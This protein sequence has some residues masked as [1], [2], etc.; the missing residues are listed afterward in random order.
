MEERRDCHAIGFV[1]LFLQPPLAL[2]QRVIALVRLYGER[3]R[4][5]VRRLVVL[6]LRA[7]G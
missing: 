2:E 4:V 7:I 3:E 5:L 6:L 1:Q